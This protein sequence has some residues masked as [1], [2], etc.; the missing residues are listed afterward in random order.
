M[1]S[2]ATGKDR[3]QPC[4]PI[5]RA[6]MLEIERRRLA[7]GISMEEVSDRAGVADRYFSKLLYADS[8][9]GRQAQWST[10]QELV[11]ALFPEGVDIE[12]RPKKGLRLGPEDLRCKIKFASA[13]KDPRTHRELMRELGKKGAEAFKRLS[14]EQRSA[15]AKKGAATR[16][17]RKLET[18]HGAPRPCVATDREAASSSPAS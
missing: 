11:D 12:L 6:V 4:T 7:L 8:P 18:P 15:S 16:K 10:I 3:T 5:Y 9:R 14:P 17:A 2:K 13:P 1:I